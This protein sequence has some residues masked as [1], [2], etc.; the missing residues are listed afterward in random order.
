MPP[1]GLWAAQYS[2]RL[3]QRRDTR[4]VGTN[5]SERTALPDRA[6][7][8]LRFVLEHG[9]PEALTEQ[10]DGETGKPRGAKALAWAQAA[11]IDTLLLRREVRRMPPARRDPGRP[12][13]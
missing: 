6:D 2:L 12:D 9:R 5:H 10:I 4:S 11:L 1:G 7:G 3:V 8:Y 13:S